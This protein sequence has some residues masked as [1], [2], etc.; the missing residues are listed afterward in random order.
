MVRFLPRDVAD[1]IT[2]GQDV[3]HPGDAEEREAAVLIIDLRGFTRFCT[4]MSPRDVVA[5]L[6]G[7]HKR[8][9][10]IVTGH[11]GV[12]DKYMGDGVMATFGAVR[13][14]PTAAA[15]ALRALQAIIA[16]AERWQQALVLPQDCVAPR[17]NGAMAAGP[18]VFAALGDEQ[19]LEFTI[20]GE[21]VNQRA[22]QASRLRPGLRARIFAQAPAGNPHRPACRRDGRPCRHRRAG[23]VR[24]C[25]PGASAALPDEANV[26]AV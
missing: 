5:I 4:S 14:S 20:I 17:V 16:E 2:S 8:I 19:R 22:R 6:V 10:P 9:V 23:P 21:A 13:H 7:F 1:V 3:V 24:A 26:E 25:A 12:V 11:E 18:V 15:D